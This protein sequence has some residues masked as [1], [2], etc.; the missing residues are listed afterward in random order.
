MLKKRI[1]PMLLL[2]QGRMVKGRQFEQFRDTGD[3]VSAAR[4]YNAQNSD[5]LFFL[6]ID[7]HREG[8]SFDILEATVKRVAAECFMPLTVGGGIDSVE[9]IQRLLLAGADK[10][11]I[12]TAAF[13]D[14]DLINRAAALFG[15]QCIVVGLDVKPSPTSSGS[16]TLYTHS[17]TQPSS[18]SL[19]DVVLDM[20][21]RGA[22]E[23]LVHA[24]DRDGMMNGYDLTVVTAVKGL[25]NRPLIVAGGAGTLMHL[26][27]AFKE[28]QVDAVACASLFHFGDNNPIRARAYLMNQGIPLKR[29]K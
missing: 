22:G 3:P 6:D 8:G 28:A 7:T 4:I 27:D 29:T 2:S 9:K 16:Y 10:V 26:V 1:I 12:T 13:E 24:I 18:R 14:P 19:Q 23:F 17:G 15:R 20:T 5:E 21:A 25:T 11:A